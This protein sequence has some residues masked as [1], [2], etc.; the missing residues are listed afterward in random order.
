MIAPIIFTTVVVGIAK[1]GDMKKVGRVG[2]KAL[3]YF[4]VVST[5]ALASA[6]SSSTSCAR[7]PASTRTCGRSIPRAIAG[8]TA[9]AKPLSTVDLL[10]HI[11][12][13][14]VVGAFASG[15]ILQVLLFSVLFGLALAR[16]GDKGK[17]LVDL[18]DQL[19]HALFGAIGI[20]MRFAPI[21]AFGAMAFTIG[22]YGVGTLVSLG[23]L[24]ALRLPTCLLFVFVVLGPIAR[25]TGFSLWHF[26]RYIR[27]R[28]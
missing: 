13:D 16:F 11:I 6:W 1:M 19:S 4:E 15:E 7:A 12:P 17:P 5:L 27:K 21:G 23:K 24:M 9:R 26:L 22:D 14:S 3:I 28:S 20:I 2:L 8:Y 18:L 10:L 25:L